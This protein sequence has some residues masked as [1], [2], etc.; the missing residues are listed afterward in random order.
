MM[1]RVWFIRQLGILFSGARIKRGITQLANVL[2]LTVIELRSTCFIM[3]IW[4]KEKRK[5]YNESN[6]LDETCSMCLTGQQCQ[7]HK[8]I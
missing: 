2:C 3:D 7:H 6:I 4:A 8:L 1:I 5:R